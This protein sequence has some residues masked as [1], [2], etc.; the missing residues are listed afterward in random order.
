MSN[1]FPEFLF[2]DRTPD[3][4]ITQ[5]NCNRIFHVRPELCF[6]CGSFSR[7]SLPFHPFKFTICGNELSLIAAVIFLPSLKN[8][9]NYFTRFAQINIFQLIDILLQC[10]NTFF[11][12][13]VVFV[14]FRKLCIHALKTVY[15]T[16]WSKPHHRNLRLEIL[17]FMLVLGPFSSNEIYCNKS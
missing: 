13:I 3:R 12:V 2:G 4:L 7:F 5:I 9:G 15:E 11:T 8:A 6:V 10:G 16:I 17:L 14:R 1:E